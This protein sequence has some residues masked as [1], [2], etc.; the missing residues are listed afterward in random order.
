MPDSPLKRAFRSAVRS[1]ADVLRGS[2]LAVRKPNL[3]VSV[4]DRGFRAGAK[5]APPR[6]RVEP[7]PA[8]SQSRSTVETDRR[9]HRSKRRPSRDAGDMPQGWAEA[10]DAT[11]A[12]YYLKGKTKQMGKPTVEDDLRAELVDQ[13]AKMIAARREAEEL[14]AL[15]TTSEAAEAAAKR[16]AAEAER[17]MR[18]HDAAEAERQA[19][20][21]KQQALE[22]KLRSRVEKLEQ[23]LDERKASERQLLTSEHALGERLKAS[24]EMCEKLQGELAAQFEHAARQTKALHDARDEEHAEHERRVN[25]LGEK[26]ST[27]SEFVKSEN[28]VDARLYVETVAPVLASLQAAVD[29]ER[30]LCQ[31]RG[32]AWRTDALD[33][34]QRRAG[35][36]RTDKGLEGG[37]VAHELVGVHLRPEL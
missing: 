18:R 16:E 2:P 34:A 9:P 23:E 26:I 35:E 37:E 4:D 19:A 31:E 32:H 17:T 25:E 15:V 36:A 24:E 10:R 8:S 3:R 13:R 12:T 11:G 29:T 30:A 21:L 20:A 33:M 14:R 5:P 22:L 7:R 6:V 28:K 27:F 1:T